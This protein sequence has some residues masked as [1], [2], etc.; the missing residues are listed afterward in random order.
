MSGW[1]L[2]QMNSVTTAPF[3]TTGLDKSNAALP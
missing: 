3:N 1:G 2:I